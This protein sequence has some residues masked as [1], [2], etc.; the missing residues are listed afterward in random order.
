[1]LFKDFFGFIFALLLVLKNIKLGVAERKAGMIESNKDTYN[2]TFLISY[3]LFKNSL[4]INNE[5]RN[6]INDIQTNRDT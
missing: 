6:L 3:D 5:I 2:S 4:F 1:M